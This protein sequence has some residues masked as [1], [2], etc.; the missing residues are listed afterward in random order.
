[1]PDIIVTKPKEKA[2][3]KRH[4]H[5][6]EA[7]YRLTLQEQRLLLWLFSE[8][9]PEDTDFKRYRVRIA[10]LAKLIGISD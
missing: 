9:K 10:D 6:I 7:R 4:N 2:L 5:L 1:M 8:I 3:V